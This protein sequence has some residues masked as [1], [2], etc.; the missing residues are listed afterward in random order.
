[1]IPMQLTS[2]RR[3]WTS[4]SVL[5]ALLTCQS[6][7]AQNIVIG[8]TSGGL[9]PISSAVSR[10]Y[11]FGVTSTAGS[12]TL[13]ALDFVI[14]KNAQSSGNIIVEVYSGLG[15][16][17]TVL[18]TVTIPASS[19]TSTAPVT[20][21]NISLGSPLVLGQGAYSIKISAPNTGTANN[22][23][24]TIRQGNLKLGTTSSGNITALPSNQWVED[25]NTTGTAGNT[26]APSAG[27]VL[28]DRSV[29]S[30]TVNLGRFHTS[31]TAPTTSI[32]YNNVAPATT[33]NVT[34]SLT[35]SQTTT[36]S[37]VVSSIP[38]THTVQGGSNNITVGVT[39]AAGAQSGTVQLNFNSV[40]TG[41]SSTRSGG[42]V[43]VGSNTITVTGTGY[44]GRSEWTANQDGSWNKNDFVRWDTNGGTPGLD[45]SVSAGD[46]ALFGTAAT[47]ARTVTLDGNAPQLRQL[48]FNNANNGYTIATG[49]GSASLELGNATNAGSMVNQAGQ[50]AISANVVLGNHLTYNG[51]A[52]SV[53]TI[54]GGIS[55]GGQGLTKQGSG[56]LR[57]TGTNT[58]TG[59]TSV[60]GGTLIVN[61]TSNSATTVNSG[62]TLGGSGTINGT[63]TISGIHS[64]GNSPGTQTF[65]SGLT[66]NA[67]AV[68]LWELIANSTDLRGTNY[69]AIDVTGALNF[70][71]TTTIQLD[72]DF[73]GSP[74]SST[75]DWNDT[76]WDQSYTGTSGWEIFRVAEGGSITGFENLQLGG[77]LLDSN[78][79]L[80]SSE[81]GAF[82]LAKVNNSIYLN[83]TVN[84][85]NI[86]NVVPEA[87]TSLLG[88]IGAAFLLRR[89]RI[90]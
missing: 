84:N 80:L 26:I 14:G 38:T 33:G 68:V 62:A 74:T 48:T 65:T 40:Q 18:R 3:G 55:G 27:Y 71:G 53:T 60:Q 42:A 21:G 8:T 7:L 44:T 51:A 85:A 30:S 11:N 72:F 56:I 31:G 4:A 49:T 19:I 59:N 10:T 36:G 23:T 87:S 69:D 88:V 25:N 45:G 77:S 52:N 89:R 35:V 17:G 61:G 66:Y 1:M 86:T 29:S 37:A 83:Y 32:S 9:E 78:G 15:G 6:A 13:S 20:Y 70:A 22:N 90:S 50:H 79:Y 28:A 43:S 2:L 64:P 5:A 82:S 16:T 39:N 63:T 81:H 47:A 41:S 75:V 58:Y 12:I 54:S 73:I 57:L 67:N 24:Y 46:T 34:E 76:F